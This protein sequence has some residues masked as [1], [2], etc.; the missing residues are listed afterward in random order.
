VTAS[1][2]PMPRRPTLAQL[3]TQ[4][5]ALTRKVAALERGAPSSGSR[6][7][8]AAAAPASDD[9]LALISRRRGAPWAQ[10][11]RRGAVVYGGSVE[12]GGREY[13]WGLERPVPGLLATD[14]SGP[15][16]VLATLAHPQRLRLL[17]ALI[18]K[19]RTAAE[20]QKAIGTRSPGPLY[21]HLRDLVALGVVTQRDRLY[22]VAAR[23]V[24]PLLTALSVA[25]DLGAG[26][27]SE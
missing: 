26:R 18:E 27:G 12:I 10:G 17:V 2:R 20:L 24:V 6:R 25:I 1:R 8:R 5:E 3:A 19:P 4:I 14:V 15:A 11:D 13:L 7:G 16:G 21:H 22:E 9:L 23:H